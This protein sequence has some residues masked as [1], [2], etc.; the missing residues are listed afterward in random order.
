MVGFFQLRH[1]D[2]GLLLGLWETMARL[3][4]NTFNAMVEPILAE[5]DSSEIVISTKTI[6]YLYYSHQYPNNK[7]I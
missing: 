5:C 1:G 2:V 7:N 3:E 6:L 4:L